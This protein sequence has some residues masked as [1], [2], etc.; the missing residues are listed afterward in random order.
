MSGYSESC[1]CG[2]GIN[3][4]R[5]W[6]LLEWRDSHIHMVELPEEQRE[7]QKDGSTASTQ[8]SYPRYFESETAFV[9]TPIIESKHVIGF[10][11]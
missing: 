5:H 1:G 3:A 2:A 11:A 10:R 7:P 8:L 6:Q 9:R 4:K